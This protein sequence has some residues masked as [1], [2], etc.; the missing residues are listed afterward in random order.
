MMHNAVPR[1]APPAPARRARRAAAVI[2]LLLLACAPQIHQFY[3]DTYY[4]EDRV[5]E[6]KPIGFTLTFRGNWIMFTDP[7]ELDGPTRGF[8][9]QLQERKAELLFVGTTVER[10]QMVR[11]IAIHLNLPPREYAERTR[12]INKGNVTE[13]EGLTDALMDGKYMV[14]WDY[15]SMGA[16]FVEFFMTVDTYNVR[17]AF[18]SDP[19]VFDQFLPIYLDIVSTLGI[20]ERL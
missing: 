13:D 17:I 18:W 20:A 1:S 6:N 12:E 5:Y 8:A 16:R 15:V 19:K 3:P 10:T 4:S 2:V 9:A 14:R 11:G 7:N